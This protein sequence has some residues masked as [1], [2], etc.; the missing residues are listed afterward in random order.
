MFGA[1]DL[2]VIG[3]L[4][5]LEGILSID[6]ALVLAMLVRP[7]PVK[8][9]RRALTWGIV[10]AVA[11]RILAISMAS[12]L[13]EWRWVK[14]VG[15]GYLIFLA[16]SHFFQKASKKEK[17]PKVRS[18]WATVAVIELTDIAFAVDSILAAVALTPKVHLVITGGLI[19]MFLM[20]FGASVFV[21]LLDRF[22]GFETSAYQLVL[23][24]GVKLI[25]EAAHLPWANF[26]DAEQLGFWGFWGTMLLCVALGFRKKR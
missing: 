25:L 19:G 9:H 14:Y 8:L 11:F 5:F 1:E 21:K 10:G 16:A 24:I 3:V 26:H 20:R 6:N 13:M 7:L 2:A 4:V 23:L 15:G 12:Q 18:F 22:P 17:K